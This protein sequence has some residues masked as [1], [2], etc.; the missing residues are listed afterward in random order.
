LLFDN[1]TNTSSF[2]LSE[3]GKI[4][5][6]T[7]KLRFFSLSS[8][9][10]ITNVLVIEEFQLVDVVFCLSR[11]H[12]CSTGDQKGA[13]RAGVEARKGLISEGPVNSQHGT[14]VEGSLL[15]CTMGYHP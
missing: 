14:S 13:L 10:N 12:M 2:L 15:A 4:S 1:F 5:F 7:L 8:T 3:N 9:I 11:H 6:F